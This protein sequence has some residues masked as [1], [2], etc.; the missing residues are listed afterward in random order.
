MQEELAYDVTASVVDQVRCECELC[1]DG[2]VEEIKLEIETY[3]KDE[4]ENA[5][6]DVM[7]RFEMEYGNS[8]LPEEK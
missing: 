4:I 5:K 6:D 2:R 8:C 3:M 1:T 7:N